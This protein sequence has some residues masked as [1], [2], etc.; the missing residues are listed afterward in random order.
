M[1]AAFLRFGLSFGLY[2]SYIVVRLSPKGRKNCGNPNKKTLKVQGSNLSYP[3]G[4]RI[5]A[6]IV[7][8]PLAPSIGPV[9]GV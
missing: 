4:G 6:Q 1:S 7:S 2:S 3:C 5:N 8:R 9:V